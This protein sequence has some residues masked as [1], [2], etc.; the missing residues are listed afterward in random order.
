MITVVQS[1]VFRDFGPLFLCFGG[2]VLL[3]LPLLG[4]ISILFCMFVIKKPD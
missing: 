4:R 3:F 1:S 2:V